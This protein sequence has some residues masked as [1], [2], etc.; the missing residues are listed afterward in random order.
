MCRLTS[1][2]KFLFIGIRVF[3]ICV[4][5]YMRIKNTYECEGMFICLYC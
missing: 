1:V 2:I 4:F 5:A 3:C